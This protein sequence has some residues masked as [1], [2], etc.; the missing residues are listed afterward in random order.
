MQLILNGVRVEKSEV[1]N[2]K[3]FTVVAA[4]AP[5]AFSHPSKFRVSSG[6][7]IGRVGDVLDLTVGV[8]GVVKA[9]SFFDRSTGQQKSFDES[10][11]FFEVQN[12]KPHQ[13][14]SPSSK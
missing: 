8:S 10:S 6:G 11:V 9:K 4:P 12:F 2:G 3:T 7:Q 1:Y 14:T 5:D 13:S